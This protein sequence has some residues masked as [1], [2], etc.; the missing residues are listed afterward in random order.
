MSTYFEALI[1]A[2]PRILDGVWITVQLTLGGAALAAVIALALGL[3][4][5][6]DNMVLRGIARAIIEFFR[7]TSLVVQ[8]F[9]MFFVLPQL[10]LELPAMVC[11]II[12]LGLNYGAYS[13]EVVRGSLNAVPTGQWEASTAL[14]LSPFHRMRRIIFPQAW[15]LM[16]PSLTN[17]LVHLLKGT[18]IV[19]FITLADLT[20]HTEQ[21]RVQT[22]TY[23]AYGVSL[24][25]YFILA[26]LLTMG[27][28]ALEVQAKHRLGRGRSLRETLS[29]ST[30]R[31]AEVGTGGAS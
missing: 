15:A 27:M 22:S 11:G 1:G 25:I 26:Y 31:S 28:N 6:L 5:R 2:A 14:S 20:Y 4:A 7:G 30:S 3:M 17:Y 18:A 21:L 13:A 19:S 16:I 12:A 9:F 23:F 24:I 10:G 29:L 8:L